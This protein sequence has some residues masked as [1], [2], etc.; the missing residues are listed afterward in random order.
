MP[1]GSPT[2]A[3]SRPTTCGP[4][5]WPRPGHFYQVAPPG[6]FLMLVAANFPTRLA[7]RYPDH[8]GSTSDPSLLALPH[9]S[10]KVWKPAVKSG[11][12][13]DR[14]RLRSRAAGSRQR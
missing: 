7:A 9:D 10:P 14:M 8:P 5:R 13:Q 3:W 11:P 6:S 4:A 2:S 1:A 12:V